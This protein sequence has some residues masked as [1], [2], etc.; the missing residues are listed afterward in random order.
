LSRALKIRSESKGRRR[1][2]WRTPPER[3]GWL[4]WQRLC[5]VV[6]D[7]PLPRC[8]RENCSRR[9]ARVRRITKGDVSKVVTIRK[10]TPLA[11]RRW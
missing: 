1:A 6:V 5:A 10:A 4:R 3:K 2:V 7:R 8:S 9:E 11:C